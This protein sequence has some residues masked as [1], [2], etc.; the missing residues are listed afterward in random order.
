[1]TKLWGFSLSELMIAL[2]VLGILSAVTV[3]AIN[4]RQVSKNKI[5]IKKAYYTTAE[6]ISELINDDKIYA[7]ATGLCPTTGE[8]GY[9]GFDCPGTNGQSTTDKFVVNFADYLNIIGEIDSSSPSYRFATND[10]MMWYFPKSGCF[11]T[12]GNVNNPCSITID[13][14]GDSRGDNEKQPS[15]SSKTEGFDQFSI[16]IYADGRMEIPEEQTWAKDAIQISS[17]LTKN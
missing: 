14:D 3:P 1:M 9:V 10:M 11:E 2:L 8:S 17:S 13:V 4:K 15:S 7:D 16:N 12:K 6:V 5:F